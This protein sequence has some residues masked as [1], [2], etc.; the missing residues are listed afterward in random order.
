MGVSNVNTANKAQLVKLALAK[1]SAKTSQSAKPDYLLMTG[2]VFS[3]PKPG[4]SSRANLTELNTR[5]SL[6]ELNEKQNPQKTPTKATTTSGKEQKEQMFSDVSSVSDGKQ[7]MSEMSGI[8]SK[9]E[10]STK[11]TE[12]NT[13]TVN[14]FAQD[15]KSLQQKT[16][17]DDKKFA[18]TV[19]T[20]QSQLKRDNEKLSKIIQETEET[21]QQVKQAQD[22]LDSL[23][24]SN[25]Y[26]NGDSSDTGK[27][28][29][30]Q[31]LIGAKVGK[32]QQNGKMIYSLQRSSSRTLRRMNRTNNFY[33]KTQKANTK[34]LQSQESSTSG[35]IK[36]ANKVE[37][38]ASYTQ[39][40]G[41]ALGLAGK[42]LVALGSSTSWL[43]GAG[44]ALIAVGT[45]MQKVG[46]VAELVGQ[47]GQ[48]AANVT[49]TAAYA[50][51]G[52]ILGAMQSVA[53]AAQ[54]GMAA[55]K[56]TKDIGKTFDAIDKQ[57][58][59]ATQKLAAKIE[60]KNIVNEM[61]E[62]NQLGGMTEKQARKYVTADLR[63]QMKGQEGLT[64]F[65]DMKEFAAQNKNGAFDKA[66]TA[67]QESQKSIADANKLIL[68]AEGKAELTNGKYVS[69]ELKKDGITNKTISEGKFNR[70]VSKNFKNKIAGIDVPKA[71]T[72]WGKEIEKLGGSITNI[73]A[74]FT[75]NKAMDA[76]S[77][78][79]PAPAGYLDARTQRIM[80]RNM[81]YRT[82][83]ASYV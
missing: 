1:K 33:I 32:L 34:A 56:G 58:Q 67:Y 49:K 18:S 17:K 35:I 22:E 28:K 37:E 62:N 39:A 5:R 46:A 9:A 40:G 51:D 23:L 10:S 15:S 65:S 69:N 30:L 7:A 82:R 72:N 4:E 26:K 60:A 45:V 80:Q 47:Y 70:Q 50:A 16:V 52:N 13:K 59:A 19:K 55:A 61:A 64:K 44:A 57:G 73:A 68:N 36:V 8:Q 27:A 31:S 76:I 20:Q 78:K 79:R 41:Q 12:K 29:D 71:S 38:I 66:K 3:A 24:A 63:N 81:A 75:Q 11:E 43:G 2:S 42:L 14:K 6:A 77:K 21:N 54:S 25:G 83:H 74:V 48:A 53:A